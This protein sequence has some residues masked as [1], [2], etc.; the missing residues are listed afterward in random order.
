MAYSFDSDIGK[1]FLG[2]DATYLVDFKQQGADTTPLVEQVDTLFNPVDLRLRGRAG[3]AYK[4]VAAN[5]FVN[6]TDGYRV[7]NTAGA[8]EISSWTTIDASL[9]YNTQEKFGDSPLSNTTLRVSVLN[10]FNEDPPSTPSNLAFEIF[11][12][13]PTNASP[14]GRFI[15]FELTKKF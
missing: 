14:L 8:A 11:G 9:A 12:F 3:Y 15:S 10:L 1:F 5:I 7:D 2:L 6:Y 13:D 4:G